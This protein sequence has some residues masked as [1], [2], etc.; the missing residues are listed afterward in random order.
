MLENKKTLEKWISKYEAR[1]GFS[2]KNVLD[3]GC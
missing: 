3:G 2:M 1:S